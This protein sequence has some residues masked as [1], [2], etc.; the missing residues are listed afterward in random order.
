MVVSF[1]LL[2]ALFVEHRRWAEA[3]GGDVKSCQASR[4]YTKSCLFGRCYARQI[5]HGGITGVARDMQISA[6]KMD[7]RFVGGDGF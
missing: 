7:Q 6:L 1:S 3:G 5:F 2:R 4:C